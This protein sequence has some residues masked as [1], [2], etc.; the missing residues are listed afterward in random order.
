VAPDDRGGKCRSGNV[1]P[2]SRGGKRGSGKLQGRI[3]RG[4]EPA[5]LNAANIR[6]NAKFMSLKFMLEFEL[7]GAVPQ[8]PYRGFA[9][10]F[11]WG[12]SVPETPLLHTT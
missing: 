8:T 11:H 3:Q 4:A 7:S 6:P 10:G 5:P 9:S 12:T 2:N 1:A